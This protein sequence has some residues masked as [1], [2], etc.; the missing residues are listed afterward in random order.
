MPFLTPGCRTY[1]SKDDDERRSEHD[2]H[3]EES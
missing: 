3:F 2:K 1:D